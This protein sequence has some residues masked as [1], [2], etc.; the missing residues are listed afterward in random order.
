MRLPFSL[1]SLSYMVLVRR[2]REAQDVRT[3]MEVVFFDVVPR[4]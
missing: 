3:S 4:F 2:A 1:F